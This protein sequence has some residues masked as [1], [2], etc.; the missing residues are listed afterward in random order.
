MENHYIQDDAGLVALCQQLAQAKVLAVDTEFVRTR[1]FYP[2]LG[3]LQVCDGRVV[4]LIDPIAIKDLS[5]FW[6]LLTNAAIKKVLHACS[7]DLEVFLT[8][9]NCRPVNLIDTQV[10]MSFLGHGLSIG[11]AAMVEHYLA[12]TLDKSDSRTD[13]TKRPLSDS[14]LVYARADVSYLYKL[15]PKLEQELAQTPWYQA[16]QQETELMVDKKFTAIDSS[17][18]YRSVKMSWR[19]NAKQLNNLKFLAQWRYQQ[20]QKR[21]LPIGFI[22]KDHT[23]IALAQKS[24]KN[25]TAMA[26][27]E[28][29]ELQDVRHKGKAMLAVLKQAEKVDAASYPDEIKRLDEY[30]GY[31]QTYKK[32]KNFVA[33][34]AEK[35]QQQPENLASKKQ[36]NQFLSWHYQLNNGGK[37]ADT[38]DVLSNWRASLFGNELLTHARS[39]FASL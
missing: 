3:L 29:V 8:Q 6:Q 24:P 13:W 16:A 39:N 31:K 34:Q 20:A 12:V 37:S 23:L 21:D 28:G 1:T 9:A 38:I 11:Y 33:K 15:F 25:T 7:E 17:E 30:P 5:P 36:I 22:A 4:G 26:A 18:L 10:M 35:H 2:R 27:I 32:I 14:Q 19:L